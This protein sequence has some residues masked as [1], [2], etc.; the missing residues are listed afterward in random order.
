MHTWWSLPA[1]ASLP[2]SKRASPSTS[3]HFVVP[4]PSLV[5][6][7]PLL[8]KYS[9]LWTNTELSVL[10]IDAFAQKVLQTCFR[11]ESCTHI[12]DEITTFRAFVYSGL[13]RCQQGCKNQFG[14]GRCQP[15]RSPQEV[16]DCCSCFEGVSSQG[17]I[18]L[19]RT[20]LTVRDW[21]RQLNQ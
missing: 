3:H 21:R 18:L 4:P 5:I 16:S 14:V 8:C 20:V 19:L 11:G 13:L 12:A 7:L 17:Y 9:Q 1:S 2:C 10:L 6:F 15:S